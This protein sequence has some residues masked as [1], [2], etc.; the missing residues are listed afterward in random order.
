MK[1][2]AIFFDIDHTLFSHT[3]HDVPASAYTAIEKLK[4]NGSRVSLC[5]S[6]T[7]EELVHLPQRL[8]SLLDGIV[9]A[10]GAV[11]I[12]QGQRVQQLTIEDDDAQR[13]IQYC[14]DHEIVIRWSSTTGDNCHNQHYTQEISDLFYF[15]Y[16]MRPEHRL[17]NHEPLINIIFYSRDDRQIEEIRALLKHSQL[18]V[19]HFANE[20]T[21]QGADKARGMLTL[22]QRWGFDQKQTIAFGDGYND[23]GMIRTAGLGIAMG[24]GCE[25]AK[26]AADYVADDIDHD[27]IFKACVHF[28]LIEED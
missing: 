16:Q 9:C 11:I 14:R 6:R 21:A 2:R 15:L 19:M 3:I 26:A 5:T 22:A 1:Q 12:D 27:A 18:M 7:P 17:W 8:L 25:Q 28:G 20:V 10:Q 13:V 23:V 4:A 24:N